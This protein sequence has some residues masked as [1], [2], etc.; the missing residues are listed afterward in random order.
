MRSNGWI[1]VDLD[2]TI[3]KYGEWQGETHIGEPIPLMLERVKNWISQGKTVKIMTAR[4]NPLGRDKEDIK[5][6]KRAIAEWT[7]KHVG[8]ELESTCSKDYNMIELWDDRAVQVT[9]NTGIRIGSLE[10]N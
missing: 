1:A 8:I 10:R 7:R 6:I 4:V 2:G 3:A 9:P 5:A